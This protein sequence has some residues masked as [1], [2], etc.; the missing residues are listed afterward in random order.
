MK[1]EKTRF[2]LALILSTAA[3]IDNITTVFALQ[4][5]AVEAN[6][7]V[8]IF[9]SNSILFAVFTVAKVFLAF[10][11]VYETFSKSVTWIA[12]YAA[13]LTLFIRASIINI[14]NTLN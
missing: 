1:I 13:V 5:G 3:L 12:I 4:R 6:P 14:L 10:Y 8:A 7:F 11:V 2:I 9:T